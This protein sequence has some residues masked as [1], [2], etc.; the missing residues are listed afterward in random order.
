MKT[1]CP[2]GV[3]CPCPGAHVY[4]H[5]IQTA[6]PMNCLANQRQILCGASLGSGNKCFYMYKWSR[7]H[8]QDG[9]QA[10]IWQKPL[11][12]LLQDRKSYDVETWHAA[13]E[14]QA[15]QKFV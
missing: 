6:S 7:S 2:Q 13:S 4:D 11:K 14:T 3:V 12:K 15:L 9:R 10:H 1:I 8:D 5:H